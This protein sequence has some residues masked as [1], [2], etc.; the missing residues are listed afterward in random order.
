MKRGP[1]EVCAPRT[2]IIWKDLASGEVISLEPEVSLAKI[3]PSSRDPLS[4]T[5]IGHATIN[6]ALTHSS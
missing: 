4:H 2:L 5:K 3:E 6:G 1:W